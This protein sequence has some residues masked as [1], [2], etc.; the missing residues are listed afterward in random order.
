MDAGILQIS[1]YEVKAISN[2]NYW[3]SLQNGQKIA[4]R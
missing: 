3:R 2:R 1:E 4:E